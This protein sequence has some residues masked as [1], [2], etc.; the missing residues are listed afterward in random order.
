MKNDQLFM[1]VSEQKQALLC[2]GFAHV[3]QMLAKGGL[4]LHRAQ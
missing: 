4:V 2:A 3:E 1:T